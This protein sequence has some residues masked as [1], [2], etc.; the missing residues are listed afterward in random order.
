MFASP[1]KISNRFFPGWI[2]QARDAPIH[3]MTG[4]NNPQITRSDFLNV[5]SACHAPFPYVVPLF[6]GMNPPPAAMRET[7]CS[8]T[9]HVSVLRHLQNGLLLLSPMA[10]PFHFPCY[11]N[12]LSFPLDICFVSFPP[13]FDLI[14]LSLPLLL[15]WENLGFMRF[16][17]LHHGCFH[18][19]RIF[20]FF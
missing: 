18:T 17:N 12:R 11:P 4:R 5:T 6:Y 8:P 14:S 7:F 15:P 9:P 10:C 3:Q 2:A 19:V 13:V 20:S 1:S 16:H